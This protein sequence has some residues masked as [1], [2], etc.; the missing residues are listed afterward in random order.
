MSRQHPLAQRLSKPATK[1]NGSPATAPRNSP[2]SSVA[3]PSAFAESR[4]RLYQKGVLSLVDQA[5][6]SG[7]NFL[8]MVLLGRTEKDELGV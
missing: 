3:A 8:T 5:V 6:V 7:T 1:H 4:C 2:T